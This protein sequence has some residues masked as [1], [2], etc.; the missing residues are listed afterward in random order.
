LRTLLDAPTLDLHPVLTTIPKVWANG[1]G[2]GGAMS[3][4]KQV[5]AAIGRVPHLDLQELKTLRENALR[6]GEDA[7]PLVQAIDARLAD[8]DAAGGLAHHRLEFGAVSLT[9]TGLY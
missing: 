8:F 5:A 9:L 3:Q 2:W 7:A 6:F 1:Q 4:N